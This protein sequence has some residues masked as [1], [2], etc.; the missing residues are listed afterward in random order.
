MSVKQS[1]RRKRGDTKIETIEK[2]YGVDFGVRRDMRLDTFLEKKG[3]SSL[4]R[5]VRSIEEK[6]K[7]KK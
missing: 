6:Q 5:A 7:K 2:Q 4:S 1:I 3:Y